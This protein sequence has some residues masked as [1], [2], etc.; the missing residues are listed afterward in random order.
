MI[1]FIQLDLVIIVT[2]TKLLMLMF[3]PEVQYI[4]KL[5]VMLYNVLVAS[6]SLSAFA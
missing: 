3:H 1:L 6:I 2:G 5:L 4:N